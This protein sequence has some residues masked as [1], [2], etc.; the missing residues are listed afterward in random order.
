VVPAKE[1]TAVDFAVGKV[2]NLRNLLYEAVAGTTALGVQSC[3]I[4][5][6]AM[7]LYSPGFFTR[8]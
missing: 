1:F 2:I 6:I 5:A 7:N 3:L 4:V 8:C